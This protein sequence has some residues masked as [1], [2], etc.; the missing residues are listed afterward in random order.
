MSDFFHN[1]WS[2]FIAASTLL[3]LA[4]C[5]WLLIIASRRK[6]M[7][8]PHGDDGTRNGLGAFAHRNVFDDEL[9]GCI[10]VGN[11]HGG[12]GVGHGRKPELHLVTQIVLG[13]HPIERGGGVVVGIGIGRDRASEAL[14][15]ALRVGTGQRFDGNLDEILRA[16]L[17][18]RGIGYPRRRER[19]IEPA[20]R[21][22]PQPARCRDQLLPPRTAFELRPAAERIRQL[23]D[24]RRRGPRAVHLF[25]R[26]Y[27]VVAMAMRHRTAKRDCRAHDL[28]HHVSHRTLLW[29]MFLVPGI[30]GSGRCMTRFR[31]AKKTPRHEAGARIRGADGGSPGS[32]GHAARTARYGRPRSSSG[33]C[34]GR[35]AR[36]R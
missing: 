23:R 5:L 32:R 31:S 20:I 33:R 27:R 6:V 3:G 24:R 10:G 28:N 21:V 26:G 30:I 34:C 11:G 7:V 22:T 8:G 2:I 1:G 18:D 14:M 12:L 4:A 9:G 16:R 29:R 15:N 25:Q 13:S 36:S 19:A 17:A 35:A